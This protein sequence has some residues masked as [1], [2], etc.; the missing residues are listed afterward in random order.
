VVERVRSRLGEHRYRLLT[1]NCEHFCEW[2]LRGESRSV[3]IERL[4][5][6]PRMAWRAFC[7]VWFLVTSAVGNLQDRQSRHLDF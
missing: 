7:T 2:A 4:H 3:Q 1:N 5:V 6:R